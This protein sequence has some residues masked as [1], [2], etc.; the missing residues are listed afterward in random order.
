M[1]RDDAKVPQPVKTPRRVAVGD[2][3]GGVERAVM[4]FFGWWAHTLVVRRVCAHTIDVVARG[5]LLDEPSISRE[6]RCLL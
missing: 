4:L 5:K 1:D 6:A 3:Q 2:L